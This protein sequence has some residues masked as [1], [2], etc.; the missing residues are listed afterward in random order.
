MKWT[1]TGGNKLWLASNHNWETLGGEN[2]GYVD[3]F[4]FDNE[5][6]CNGPRCKDCGFTGCWHCKT[7]CPPCPK[8]ENN[9]Q[10]KR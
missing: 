7:T 9:G 5:Y 8:G 1:N 6:H 4:A 10:T 3:M 2:P